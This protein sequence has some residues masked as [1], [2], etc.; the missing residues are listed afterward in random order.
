M[1]NAMIDIERTRFI[2]AIEIKFIQIDMK[3][4]YTTLN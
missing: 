2:L 4:E 3:Y 1:V